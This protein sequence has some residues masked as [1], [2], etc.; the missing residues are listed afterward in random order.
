MQLHTRGEWAHIH[1]SEMG[2]ASRDPVTDA[3]T[4]LYMQ[5]Q[6]KA[7]SRQEASVMQNGYGIRA[8]ALDQSREEL[9]LLFIFQKEKKRACRKNNGLT[10]SSEGIR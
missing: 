1:R 4:S 3:N 2:K 9:N 5:I 6:A 8:N 10:E 7:P